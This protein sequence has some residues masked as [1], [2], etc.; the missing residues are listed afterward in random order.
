MAQKKAKAKAEKPCN[1]YVCQGVRKG[2]TEEEAIIEAIV[3]T[4]KLF[5][6]RGMVLHYEVD[7]QY[8]YGLNI[9]THGLKEAHGVK[10]LQVVAPMYGETL[11]HSINEALR[12]QTLIKEKDPKKR[13]KKHRVLVIDCSCGKPE[14]AFGLTPAHEGGRDLLRIIFPDS[15]GVFEPKQ[16]AKWSQYQFVLLDDRQK[17]PGPVPEAWTQVN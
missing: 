7:E 13:F 14:H 8:P 17:D 5:E 10:D 12:I 6:K 16:M 3:K 9:H 11:W 1:C 4:V 2:L 15:E